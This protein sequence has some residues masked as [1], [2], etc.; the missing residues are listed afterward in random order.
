MNSFEALIEDLE[1]SIL[2]KKIETIKY[3]GE[4]QYKE[5][6]PILL[7]LL[8][9]EED[10]NVL[11]ALALSLGKLECNEAVPILMNYIRNPKFKNTRGSFIYALLDLDCREYFLDFARMICEGDFEVYS[12]SFSIFESIVDD[13]SYELKFEAKKIL[14]RQQKIELTKTE[15]KYPQY[16]RINYINEALEL[17]N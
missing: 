5:F 9:N 17:L 4:V 7:K 6:E 13:V 2:E 14:E 10:I 8:S 15:S 11:N 16:E 3:I 1:S 12:H